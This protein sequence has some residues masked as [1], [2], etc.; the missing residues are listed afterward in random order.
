MTVLSECDGAAHVPR[1]HAVI[2]YLTQH[3]A[4]MV[5]HDIEELEDLQDIVERGP[6]WNTIEKIEV[7]LQRRS[8]RPGLTVEESG[9]Q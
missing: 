4:N 1:W 8:D 7:T 9:K 2:T 3:G 6:S 5:E